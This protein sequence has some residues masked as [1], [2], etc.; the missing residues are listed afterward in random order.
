MKSTPPLAICFISASGLHSNGYDFNVYLRNVPDGLTLNPR[1][2][3]NSGI[4]EV[5]AESFF[6]N[7]D[8]QPGL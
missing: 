1:I 4:L 3:C 8:S 7:G 2:E 6:M 5:S